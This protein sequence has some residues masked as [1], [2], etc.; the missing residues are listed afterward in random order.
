VE[1]VVA[2]HKAGAIIT[3]EILADDKSLGQSVGRRLF[4]ILEADTEVAAIAEQTL[5]A[6]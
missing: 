5:E 4:G 2:K 3:Y 1:N 6:G